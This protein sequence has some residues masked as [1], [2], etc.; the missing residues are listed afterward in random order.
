MRGV[1]GRGRDV[2][3]GAGESLAGRVS[4]PGPRV[5]RSQPG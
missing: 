1:N 2:R 3:G 5:N 4:G